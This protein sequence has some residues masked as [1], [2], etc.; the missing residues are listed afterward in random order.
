MSNRVLNT[1]AVLSIAA[2]IAVT[3]MNHYVTQV[4]TNYFLQ[5]SEAEA[6]ELARARQVEIAQSMAHRGYF[7]LENSNHQA[8]ALLAERDEA[9]KIAQDLWAAQRELAG[10][11][12]ALSER[13]RELEAALEEAN[14]KLEPKPAPKP[15]PRLK[16]KPGG[17]L[18]SNSRF[19]P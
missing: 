1:L 16:T 10:F 13:V 9:R 18:V 15:A 7:L 14:K 6:R 8:A 19:A 4:N 11:A 2:C 12:Q 5:A 17:K 3:A